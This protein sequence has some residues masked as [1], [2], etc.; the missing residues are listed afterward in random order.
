MA[1]GT[2]RPAGYGITALVLGIVGGLGF[3]VDM[4]RTYEKR[5]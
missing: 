3:V 2:E 4:Y 5:D 1:D